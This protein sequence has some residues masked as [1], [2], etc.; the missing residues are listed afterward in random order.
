MDGSEGV[1]LQ[2]LICT[3]G[4]DGIRRVA[5]CDHPSVQGVE[6]LVS[7]QLPDGDCDIP[8]E[9]HRDD[10]RIKKNPTKGLS[11]NRNIAMDVAAAPVCLISDDDIDY[12]VDGLRSVIDVFDKCPD[13]DIATFQYDG[14]DHKAYPSVQADLSK[15]PK[16]YF[17]SSVEIAFRLESI[18]KSG[19]RFDERFGVGSEFVAGEENLWIHD[20]LREGLKGRFFP[21]NIATHRGETTGVRLETAPEYIVSKGAVFKHIHPLT[22]RLHMVAHALRCRKTGWTLGMMRY[23]K[24]WIRGVSKVSDRL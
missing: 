2:V 22:W 20:L 15:P 21:I 16:N 10:F 14:D 8:D 18:R 23:C 13:I 4:P 19:V 5:N 12:N 6:Y 11:R 1:K 17:V 9:L 7:W 3:F 24:E